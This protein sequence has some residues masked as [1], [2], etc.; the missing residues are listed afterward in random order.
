MIPGYL[1]TI[2]AAVPIVLGRDWEGVENSVRW[3]RSV[4]VDARA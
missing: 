2:G 3:A 4:P 1:V